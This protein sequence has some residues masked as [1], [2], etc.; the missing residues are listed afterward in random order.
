MTSM[1]IRS[2]I[3]ILA[4]AVLLVT[5][6]TRNAAAQQ[7]TPVPPQ[8]PAVETA[9]AA[10]GLPQ[11]PEPAPSSG[12][13]APQQGQGAAQAPVGTAA[14]PYGQ[15]VGV[16]GTRPAGAAIAPARQRRV[17]AL[18]IKMS[19]ILAA[20]A[21]TGTVIALSQASPGRPQ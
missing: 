15:P 13:G 4:G 14:A 5:A 7:S 3:A 6:S 20:A 9:S 21:A 18:V 8:D 16:A 1:R 19:I 2:A 10:E 12:Q 11:A 17:H